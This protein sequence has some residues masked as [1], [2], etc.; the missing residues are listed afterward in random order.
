MY[1]QGWT[2]AHGPKNDATYENVTCN[3]CH[4]LPDRFKD[5]QNAWSEEQ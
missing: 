4:R 2:D 5:R 3:A 1:A